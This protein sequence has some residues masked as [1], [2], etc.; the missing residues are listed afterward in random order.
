MA[1]YSPNAVTAA[2][3][4]PLLI[5]VVSSL[6]FSEATVGQ[7]KPLAFIQLVS[8]SGVLVPYSQITPFWRYTIY[9][10]NPFNYLMGGMLVFPIW[11][12]DV[13]CRMEE[14]ARFTPPQGQTCQAYMAPFMEANPGYL[15]DP[16]STT[17]C[18]YCIYSKGSISAT[19]FA[20]PPPTSASVTDHPTPTL[21][22]SGSH[23]LRVSRHVE[24]RQAHLRLAGHLY[25]V[26]LLSVVLPFRFHLDEGKLPLFGSPISCECQ[27]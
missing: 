26:S 13:E 12:V 11:D 20:F 25:H 23:R 19:P 22:P 8:F 7:L 10:V 1:A 2:L 18:L 14:F 4:N 6:L 21:L 24:P 15:Q 9:Y 5:G 17:E 27:S 3:V 16:Q